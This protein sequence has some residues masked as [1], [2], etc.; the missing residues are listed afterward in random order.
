MKPFKL[1]SRYEYDDMDEIIS[2]FRGNYIVESIGDKKEDVIL[3]TNNKNFHKYT[4]GM[5]NIYSLV[6][7]DM[8]ITCLKT[9]PYNI[10]CSLKELSLVNIT[11]AK[12]IKLRDINI[13]TLRLIENDYDYISESAY[14]IEISIGEGRKLIIDSSILD[15]TIDPKIHTISSDPNGIYAKQCNIKLSYHV[16]KHLSVPY[17][18]FPDMINKQLTRNLTSLRLSKGVTPVEI[19]NKFPNLIDISVIVDNPEK[20]IHDIDDNIFSNLESIHLTSKGDYYDSYNNEEKCSQSALKYVY[21]DGF[22]SSLYE[23]N[24]KHC[25]YLDTLSMMNPYN[26]GIPSISHPSLTNLYF[27]CG[28]DKPPELNDEHLKCLRLYRVDLDKLSGIE[29]CLYP[30]DTKLHNLY[31]KSFPIRMDSYMM[32]SDIL[33]EAIRETIRT[34]FDGYPDLLVDN[35]SESQ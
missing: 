14:G 7:I 28:N 13:D 30:C 26:T 19:I 33:I 11:H 1:I 2:A 21:I 27:D 8:D 29:L 3:V 15:L 34:S 31:I 9:L 25:R 35:N 5:Y 18:Y 22:R 20:F 32:C 12:S 17:E 6:L 4:R 23:F 16:P 24:L 10:L